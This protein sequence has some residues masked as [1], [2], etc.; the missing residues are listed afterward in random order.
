MMT[1]KVLIQDVLYQLNCVRTRYFHTVQ[2]T[3]ITFV[4]QMKPIESY[5]DPSS[6]PLQ[7]TMILPTS[8]PLQATMILPPSLY[9]LL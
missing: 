4:N 8:L 9:K 5:Y 6:L 7:A 3:N 2:N 1:L